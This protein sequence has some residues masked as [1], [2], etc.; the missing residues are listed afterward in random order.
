MPSPAQIL[1]EQQS[2]SFVQELPVGWQV[3]AQG[4]VAGQDT[5]PPQPSLGVLAERPHAVGQISVPAGVQVSSSSPAGSQAC[6]LQG[7]VIEAAQDPGPLTRVLVLVPPPQS[8]VH[9]LHSPYTQSGC[10][11]DTLVIWLITGTGTIPKSRKRIPKIQVTFL[12][13]FRFLFIFPSV[14]LFTYFYDSLDKY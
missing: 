7:S 8:A 9:A 5:T 1:P 11:A 2:A 6:V 13:L 12:K 14:L 3:G 10:P 4:S